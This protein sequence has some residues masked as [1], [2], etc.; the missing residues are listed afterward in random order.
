MTPEQQFAA[1]LARALAAEKARERLREGAG[2]VLVPLPE[3]WE[4]SAEVPR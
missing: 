2:T 1:D 3:P 4:P